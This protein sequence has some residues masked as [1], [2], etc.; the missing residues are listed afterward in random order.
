VGREP[1]RRSPLITNSNAK[2]EPGVCGISGHPVW[3]FGA[4]HVRSV[5]YIQQH[6]PASQ[7]QPVRVLW[8]R[9]TPIMAIVLPPFGGVTLL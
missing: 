4:M 3:Y 2:R 7:L 9:G 8:K 5:A 6:A 1:A